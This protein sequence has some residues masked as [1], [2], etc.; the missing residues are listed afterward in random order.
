V[1]YPHPSNNI[2][3]PDNSTFPPDNLCT[4]LYILGTHYPTTPTPHTCFAPHQIPSHCP[5][6]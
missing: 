5:L 2:A 3:I 6:F 1:H 4:L